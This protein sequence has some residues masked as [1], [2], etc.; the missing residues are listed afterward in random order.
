MVKKEEEAGDAPSTSEVKQEEPKQE[1]AKEEE[2]GRPTKRAKK[3]A[4]GAAMATTTKAVEDIVDLAELDDDVDNM[5]GNRVEDGTRDL[6]LAQV[7][8]KFKSKNK[9]RFI[10]KSGIMQI[11]GLE[12]V[13]EKGN[14]DFKW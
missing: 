11:D 6:V 3:E 2:E 14:G 4:P 1:D 12:Y 8:K 5:I 13:F 10:F 9:Y 7:E